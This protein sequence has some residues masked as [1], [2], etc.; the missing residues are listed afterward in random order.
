MQSHGEIL[1]N[2]ELKE[3]AQHTNQSEFRTSDA[4]EETL[5]RELWD[6]LSKVTTII[7]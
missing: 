6:L 1:T 5:V 4:E 2:D 7:T 3:L